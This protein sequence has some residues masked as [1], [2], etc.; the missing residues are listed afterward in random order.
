MSFCYN[1]LMDTPSKIKCLAC[2]VMLAG[3]AVA[4][5]LHPFCHDCKRESASHIPERETPI[6]VY[7]FY[8]AAVS[9]FTDTAGAYPFWSVSS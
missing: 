3:I 8:G 7:N 9:G 4:E 2:G 6:A 5:L 1:M